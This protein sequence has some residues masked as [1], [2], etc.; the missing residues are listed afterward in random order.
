GLQDEKGL[1]AYEAALN[2]LLRKQPIAVANY[3]TAGTPLDQPGKPRDIVDPYGTISFSSELVFE[4]IPFAPAHH[5]STICEAGNRDLL[6]LWYGGSY[7]SAHDQ[8]IFLARKKPEEKSWSKPQVLLQNGVTPPGNGV[9]FRT[10]D[11]RIWV[12]WCRMEGTRPMRRG[13]GWNR[14]R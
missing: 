8:V 3:P 11:D 1:Q 12:V 5:C 2:N 9:I 14:C 6:C 7:E 13:S 4:K 10:P